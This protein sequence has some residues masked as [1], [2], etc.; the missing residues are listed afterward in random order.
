MREIDLKGKCS[1]IEDAV[2]IFVDENPEEVERYASAEDLGGEG[3]AVCY[4]VGTPP[5]TVFQSYV[6]SHCFLFRG[7]CDHFGI[8]PD[9]IEF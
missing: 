4:Y 9:N 5:N 8:Y 7:V 1:A 2:F 6:Q 3:Q